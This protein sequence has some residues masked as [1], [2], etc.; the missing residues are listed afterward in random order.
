MACAKYIYVDMA[1]NQLL[2]IGKILFKTLVMTKFCNN[3]YGWPKYHHENILKLLCVKHY[4]LLGYDKNI[5][6]RLVLSFD[7]K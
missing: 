4:E 2:Y 1:I 5:D 3:N 6:P 7:V